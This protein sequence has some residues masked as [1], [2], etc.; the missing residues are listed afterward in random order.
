MGSTFFDCRVEKNF[1]QL[2]ISE[3]ITKKTEKSQILKEKPNLKNKK[4]IR[5]KK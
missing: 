5:S 1:T 3:E 2:E 4:E